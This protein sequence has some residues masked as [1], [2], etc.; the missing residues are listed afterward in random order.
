MT[1]LEIAR[2]IQHQ[3][4]ATDPMALWAWG[5]KDYVALNEGKMGEN[6]VLG[7]LQFKVSGMKHK[8]LVLVRLMGNDTYT[9]EIGKVWKGEWKSK[10]IVSDVYCDMLME[11]I[12]GLVER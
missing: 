4:K 3:I 6:Y 9:V 11:T 7:G 1:S 10:A 12:D 5:S 8:G 2:T